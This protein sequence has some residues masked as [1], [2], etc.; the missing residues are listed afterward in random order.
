MLVPDAEESMRGEGAAPSTI[1]SHALL[2]G[3]HRD[4]ASEAT[5]GGG[6]C[7]AHARDPGGRCPGNRFMD[8]RI[9][10]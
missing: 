9:N 7:L 6:A 3:G 5:S 4:H 2:G 10:D 8:G 1:P